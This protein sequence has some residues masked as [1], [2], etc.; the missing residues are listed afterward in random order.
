MKKWLII[1]LILLVLMGAGLFQFHRLGGFN[2]VELA[3]KSVDGLALQ[4]ISFRGTP[5]D[6]AI[7]RVFQ[8]MEQ[9]ALGADL[10]LHTIY[11]VEPAG[12]LDTMEVFVGVQTRVPMEDF[13]QLSFD[14]DQA[15]VATIK[16][17]RLVMPGPSKVKK[18]IN[19]FA[20]GQGLA[21][22]Y[23]YIDKIIGPEEVQVL[24]LIRK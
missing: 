2:E 8:K 23:L 16:A 24:G 6:D 11:Y 18:K 10:P 13:E 3:L 15:V 19:Q 7:A 17:H 1:S 20:K 22:P 4:G 12:K 5:Q 9:I 14:A 21:V